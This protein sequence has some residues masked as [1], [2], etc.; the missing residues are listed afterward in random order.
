MPDGAAAIVQNRWLLTFD[1]H[2]LKPV[3]QSR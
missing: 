1:G 2:G 3:P